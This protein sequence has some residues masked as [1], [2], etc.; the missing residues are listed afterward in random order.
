MSERLQPGDLLTISEVA[1]LLRIRPS[2]VRS[3]LTPHG[4][5]PKLA[6]IKVGR[7]VR[8]SRR[9]LDELVNAGRLNAR[10]WTDE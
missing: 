6:R 8:I 2:T 1:D 3:W 10:E 4:G 5:K 9:S 7:L